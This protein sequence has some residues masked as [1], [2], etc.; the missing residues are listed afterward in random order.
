MKYLFM[1]RLTSDTGFAP[2][3]DKRLLSLACCKGGQIR[4]GKAV[5]T[6]LR[7][8][9]GCKRNGIDYSKDDV[10]ILGLYRGKFLYLARVTDVITMTEYYGTFSKGRLDDIYSLING[11]LVRNH[12]LWNESV[13]IDEEQNIR[14]IAGEY[15]I[16]SDDFIYLGKDAVD[17]ELIKRYAPPFRGRKIYDG[18]T[19]EKIIA[20]CMKY[21]DNKIHKPNTPIRKRACCK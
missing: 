5:K 20:E 12:N 11:H 10:Y 8:E 1:Y 16:L 9:I 2:C 17:I 15:V 19:A 4:N 3:V 6:G 21:K 18:K 7:Y 14:D 13:H